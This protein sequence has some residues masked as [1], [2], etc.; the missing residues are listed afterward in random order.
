M[1]SEKRFSYTV[2]GD[3]VNQAARF[4]PANKDYETLI[5][6]GQSTYELAKNDIEARLLDKIIVKGKT[7]PI[8]VYE[9]MAKKDEISDHQRQVLELYDLGLKIHWKRNFEKAIQ[10]FE[11]VL[12]I[13]ADDGPSLTMIERVKKYIEVPPPDTWQGEF[14]RATK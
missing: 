11:Q 14:V 1:G 10:Y 9:L 4:E 3:A 6:I 2:M 13:I 7:V 8:Q 5:M 12:A